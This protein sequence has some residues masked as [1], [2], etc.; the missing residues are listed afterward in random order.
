MKSLKFVI[1]GALFRNGLLENEKE[2]AFDFYIKNINAK[3]I[4]L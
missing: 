2:E 1:L 4:T 3:R